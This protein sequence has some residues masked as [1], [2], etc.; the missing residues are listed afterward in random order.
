MT[1]VFQNDVTTKIPLYVPQ[2]SGD[3]AGATGLTLTAMLQKN[4]G[5]PVPAKGTIAAGAG[6]AYWL[7]PDPGDRD[8]VG[9]VFVTLSGIPGGDVQLPGAYTVLPPQSPPGIS[10][11]GLSATDSLNLAALVAH[12][13]KIDANIRVLAQSLAPNPLKEQIQ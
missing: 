13:A 8:V 4:G 11:G 1:Q 9:P 10:L 2:N 5:G 6:G 3:F 7:N 12:A